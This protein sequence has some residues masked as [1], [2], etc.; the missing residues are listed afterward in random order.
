MAN[1]NSLYNKYSRYVAGG[2]A[3]TANS[4]IEWWER[5]QLQTDNSDIIYAVENFYEGRLDLIA[6]VFYNEPRYWWVIA[7][8]N[9]VLD[10]VSEITAGRILRIPTKDRLPLM[11]SSKPG[12]I[13]STRESVNTISPI[14]T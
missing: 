6:S 13:D 5:N 12:G 8:Y 4:R 2:V 3:E 9:N 11:L 7:Q 1:A 10:P 14:V